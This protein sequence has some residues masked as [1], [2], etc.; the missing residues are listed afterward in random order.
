LDNPLTSKPVA[1]S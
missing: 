1:R